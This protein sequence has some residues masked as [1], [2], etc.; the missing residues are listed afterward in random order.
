[1]WISSYHY[2][3]VM[4]RE[5]INAFSTLMIAKCENE[6]FL[7]FLLIFS[8]HEYLSQDLTLDCVAGSI[9]L[10]CSSRDNDAT[11]PVEDLG[12]LFLKRLSRGKPP[13]SSTSPLVSYI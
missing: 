11:L 4:D 5:V 7:I 13:A 1:M 10:R 6:T 9:F 2:P 12:A 8:L 3:F